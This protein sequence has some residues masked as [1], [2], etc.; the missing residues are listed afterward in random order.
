M[1]ATC[2]NGHRDTYLHLFNSPSQLWSS[3]TI[4][5]NVLWLKP[6]RA[7]PTLCF[8][9]WPSPLSFNTKGQVRLTC[10][11]ALTDCLG[12]LQP[13]KRDRLLTS[14]AGRRHF[15]S[16]VILLWSLLSLHHHC[17][18][19]AEGEQV[20]W[21][22]REVK[23]R[24]I[25]FVWH[26]SMLAFKEDVEGFC[27]IILWPIQLYFCCWNNMIARLCTSLWNFKIETEKKDLESDCITK[28]T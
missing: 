6:H 8:Y 16:S 14:I 21:G 28:M 3:W 23:R 2:V 22:H 17:S 11:R 7:A 20:R 27:P 9:C 19:L 12:S 5:S 13:L 1:C 15:R 25:S 24:V 26:V 4:T 18:G 10:P